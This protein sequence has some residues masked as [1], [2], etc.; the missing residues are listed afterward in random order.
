LRGEAM[1]LH[2][3]R[4]GHQVGS[5]CNTVNSNYGTTSDKSAFPMPEALL[6]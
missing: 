1:G 4:V 6:V 3:F 5:N 2:Y